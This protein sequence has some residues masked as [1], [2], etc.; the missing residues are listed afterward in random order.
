VFYLEE[1]RI[2]RTELDGGKTTALDFTAVIDVDAVQLNQQKFREAWQMLNS[3]FYDPSFHGADWQAAGEKYRP[4]VDQIRTESEFGN[5]LRELMGELRASHLDVYSREPGP[6]ATV[7][8]GETGITLDFPELDR[9]GNFRVAQVIPESPAALAGI[10]P[11]SY[12]TALNRVPLTPRTD[13]FAPLAGTIGHRLTMTIGDKPGQKGRDVYLKPISNDSLST[14]VYRDWVAGR[15]RMVDSLSQGRLAY[16]H[17]PAMSGGQL[18]RFK[19][20][21]VSIAESKDGL[22]IDVRNNSGGSIAVHLLGILERTPY[23]LRRFRD[24]PLTSENKMRSKALEK[25]MTLLI[26]GYSVSNA[27]IF[28]EGFRRLKLGKIIGEPTAGGVIGT[29]SYSLIDGTTIRRPSWGA[30]TLDMEDTDLAPRHPDIV[31]ENLPD[32]F[33]NGRDPQLVR[34][35]QELMKQLR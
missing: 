12:I 16:I 29:G 27:E 2:K 10:T 24:F 1:G 34:A 14:L 15:R 8:T 17:I 20:Q 5:L 4:L 33:I 18:E 9:N 21:L 22:V 25:P 30:Y 23:F 26:N 28:A 3:Y 31:V 11:G 7:V 13:F 35:I 32:D 19:E 6:D